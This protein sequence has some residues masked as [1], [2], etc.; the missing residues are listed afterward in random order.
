M[1]GIEKTLSSVE[2]SQMVKREH[3]SVLRDIR[4][5][6]NQLGEHKDVR[7][8]FVESS[9]IDMQEKT[10]PCF[11]FTKLGCELYGTRMIGER[12]TQ[13]AASYIERFN[14][15]ENH[16]SSVT[17]LQDPEDILIATLQNIKNV[18]EN[19]R[20]IQDDV[21]ELRNEIDLT[22][23]QKSELSKRV[24][25]NV[26]RAVGGKSSQAYK[27]LYKVAISEHWR[28]IKNY[29]EVSSYEEIPKIRFEEAL[30]LASCWQPS[31]ELSMKI[32]QANQQLMLA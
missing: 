11:Q 13:F 20:S 15:M 19:V 10:R 6:I 23:K 30:E 22:R 4:T 9:Y 1:L 12:G 31:A 29:F 7:A 2:V 26:M 16:L 5:I 14:Q 3:K 18:K 24:K 25:L 27:S 32:K 17:Q 21:T 8:Y 28:S